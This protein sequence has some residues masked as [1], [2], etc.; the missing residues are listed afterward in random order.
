MTRDWFAPNPDSNK[1]REIREKAEKKGWSLPSWMNYRMATIFKYEGH[2]VAKD[3][4]NPDDRPTL[5]RKK[6]IATSGGKDYMEEVEEYNISP[7]LTSETP[8]PLPDTGKQQQMMKSTQSWSREGPLLP[9]EGLP[10]PKELRNS[11]RGKNAK[12][13]LQ[14]YFTRFQ[15]DDQR[16]YDHR[17][18]P[19]RIGK[20]N[21]KWGLYVG[22]QKMEKGK[23]GFVRVSRRVKVAGGRNVRVFDA[24]AIENV[25][26]PVCKRKKGELCIR[27][28][29]GKILPLYET[30]RGRIKKYMQTLR[31]DSKKRKEYEELKYRGYRGDTGI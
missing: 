3:A 19:V 6:A 11:T 22:L 10:S 15:E 28:S 27:E 4:I 9:K 24:E 12:V 13:K 26:C 2:G 17:I 31:K 8:H 20:K 1:A 5:K 25:D 30:H 21:Y 29:T 18:L 14:E 7:Y 16:E 23:S